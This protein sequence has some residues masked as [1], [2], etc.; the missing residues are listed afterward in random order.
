MIGTLLLIPTLAGAAAFGLRSDGP[1]RVLLV[2]AAL[3]HAALTAAGLQV[4]VSLTGLTLDT[5]LTGCFIDTSGTITA[6]F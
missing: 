4:S 6:G 5:N 2:L 3:L 1:R